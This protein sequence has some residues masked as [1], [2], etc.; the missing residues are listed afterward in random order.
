MGAE[1]VWRRGNYLENVHCVGGRKE[2]YQM[3]RA[4]G[5]TEKCFC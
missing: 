5:S 3:E 2:E 1:E 4:V